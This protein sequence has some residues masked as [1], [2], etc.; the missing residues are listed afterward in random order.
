MLWN[1]VTW[2]RQVGHVPWS[3]IPHC[4][5]GTTLQSTNHS[6]LKSSVC[7]SCAILKMKAVMWKKKLQGTLW[8]VGV[9]DSWNDLL[10]VPTRML[11]PQ[12]IVIGEYQLWG[13]LDFVI[14]W[15]LCKTVTVWF[16][17]STKNS[18]FDVRKRSSFASEYVSLNVQVTLTA[19]QQQGHW[20][21]MLLD[22]LGFGK[23]NT[24]FGSGTK[25]TSS[26]GNMLMYLKFTLNGNWLMTRSTQ[27]FLE[28]RGGRTPLY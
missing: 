12:H 5:P 2:L 11:T 8:K 28:A 21:F 4:A 7:C 19:C 27:A 14:T 10:K 6:P 15:L 9:D 23:K 3:T 22:W 16:N 20:T 13:D 18:W 26:T 25:M 24:C 17:L 1:C